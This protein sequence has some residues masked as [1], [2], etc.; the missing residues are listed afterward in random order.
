MTLNKQNFSMWLGLF[1]VLGHILVTIGLW[2][3]FDYDISDGVV[4]KEV[5]LPITLAYATGVVKWFTS[6]DGLIKSQEM[7]GLPFA[8]LIV[9]IFVSFIG[10]LVISPILY[11]ESKQISSNEL[12]TIYLTIESAFGA[13]FALISAH[14]YPQTSAD[15]S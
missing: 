5:S 7:I 11:A 9:L 1:I 10:G 13:L 12:N 6:H 2:F 8:L 4:I 14:L 15:K 3:A